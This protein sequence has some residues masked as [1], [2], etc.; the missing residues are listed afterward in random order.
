VQKQGQV[1]APVNKFY[2]PH[3][4]LINVTSNVQKQLCDVPS[5]GEPYK[6]RAPVNKCYVPHS[7]LINVTSNVQ[8]QL[9]DVPSVGEPYKFHKNTICIAIV[10]KNYCTER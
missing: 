7:L 8:K 2:V 4:L 10:A 9:C 6:F 1:R 5:V 3:S